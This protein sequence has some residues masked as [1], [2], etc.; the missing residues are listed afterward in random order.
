[1]APYQPEV[2]PVLET[3][4]LITAR[5]QFFAYMRTPRFYLVLFIGQ[6]LSLCITGTNTFSGL[7][8]SRG[9]SIPAFQSLFNYVLL[10]IVYTSYTL[11]K[12]GF[13]GYLKMLKER[14]WKYLILAFLDVEGNYFVVLAYRYTTV[15]SAQL[16][17][18]WAIVVVVIIS[19]AF[20]RVRYHWTQVVGILICC[21]GMGLLL[22]RDA[23]NGM[24]VGGIPTELKGDLFMLLGASFYGLTNVA[25][26]F[27]VSQS[28]LYEVVGQIG[29][30]GMLI[31]GAQAAIFDRS[32]FQSATWTSEVGW[33]LT[34]FTLIM[35]IFYST[36]PILLRLASAAF[37]NISL[38][39]SNFYGVAIGIRVFGYVLDKYYPLAFVMIIVG[40]VIYFMFISVYGEAKKPWL[41]DDQ[42]AGVVGVGTAKKMALKE[43]AAVGPQGD[44]VV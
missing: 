34:G 16:I 11:Y 12:Y 39:T 36:V 7:L 22:G 17:N 37:F 38:L 35:F 20:L 6:I 4:P 9:T 1:M 43:P 44:R 10:N 23:H 19:F 42:A 5:R 8:A 32:Q 18:F 21:G 25:E 24:T 14:G 27:L 15:I 2:T 31:S 41:G 28:P 30:W 29:F 33:Y 40:L 26:E 3:S 13:R